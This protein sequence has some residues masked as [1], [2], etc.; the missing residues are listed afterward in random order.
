MTDFILY[1][2][3]DWPQSFQYIDSSQNGIDI[4]DAVILFV[5]STPGAPPTVIHKSTT[6]S[7]IV[8][9]DQDANPG[10]FTVNIAGTDTTGMGNKTFV[11]EIKVTMGTPTIARVI[12]P[13]P[14]LSASFNVDASLTDGVSP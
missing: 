7:T 1:A 2:D 13:A 8:I 4:T 9:S 14:G 5:A 6:A 3:E 11:Y 10:Q 12:Y